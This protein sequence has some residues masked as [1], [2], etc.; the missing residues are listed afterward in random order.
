MHVVSKRYAKA[1]ADILPADQAQVGMDGLRRLSF[2]LDTEPDVRKLLMNPAVRQE[3]REAFMTRLSAAL[4]LESPVY[5]LFLLLVERRRLNI[6]AEV[7]DAYQALL[8]E[9]T[10][11]LRVQVTTA[12]ALDPAAQRTLSA[13]LEKSTGKRVVMEVA[14]D[15]AILGG[16]VVQV[17]GTVM[18]ASLRQQLASVRQVLRGE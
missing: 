13:G 9:R 16:L 8:D 7:V 15:P 4:D 17:G 18:D 12:V 6:L 5:R 3:R 11:T 10:G 1:L 2:V 14:D